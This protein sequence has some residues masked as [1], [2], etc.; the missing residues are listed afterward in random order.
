[1][2]C[3]STQNVSPFS[4]RSGF[5][6]SLRIT[7]VFV[8]S[9]NRTKRRSCRPLQMVASQ[10]LSLF[11]GYLGHCHRATACCRSH[12]RC[13]AGIFP[14]KENSHGRAGDRTR[15]LMISSQRLWPLDHEAGQGQAK[16]IKRTFTVL[17]AHQKNCKLCGSDRRHF[18]PTVRINWRIDERIFM[19]YIPVLIKVWHKCAERG[20]TPFPLT[21]QI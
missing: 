9:F 3:T 17:R 18:W 6:H 2:L 8:P 19:T 14:F 16:I 5:S 20:F 15:D 4:D 1:M 11:A 12:V 13:R 10:L 7:T 21:W